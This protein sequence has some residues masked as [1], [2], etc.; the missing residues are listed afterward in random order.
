MRNYKLCARIRKLVSCHGAIRRQRAV[1]SCKQ[2]RNHQSHGGRYACKALAVIQV[3]RC[4]ASNHASPQAGLGGRALYPPMSEHCTGPKV[5]H[6]RATVGLADEVAAMGSRQSC[7]AHRRVGRAGGIHW[8]ESQQPARH[9]QPQGQA[10]S[11]ALPHAVLPLQSE[12]VFP[13]RTDACMPQG[14]AD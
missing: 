12:R 13:S 11:A 6:S 3:A 8:E 9:C 5:A 4:E 7:R 14:T 1:P 10:P 2:G